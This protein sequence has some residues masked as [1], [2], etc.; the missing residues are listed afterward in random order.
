MAEQAVWHLKRV[1]LAIPVP[2][3][4]AI[5]TRIWMLGPPLLLGLLAALI[6]MQLQT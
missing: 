3:I 5:R 2:S 4:A 6:A 1:P